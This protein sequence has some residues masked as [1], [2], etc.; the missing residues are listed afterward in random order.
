MKT[1]SIKNIVRKNNQRPNSKVLK[2]N[3]YPAIQY[4]TD[5]GHGGST[6][7][8][9]ENM[10]IFIVEGRFKFAFGKMDYTILES[11]MVFLKKDILIEHVVDTPSDFTN[12]SK[13]I[14]IQ[15]KQDLVKE[16]IKLARVSIKTQEES[17][18][19]IVDGID[20][21]LLN[22]IGSL[23]P[24]FAEPEKV[25]DHL[26]KIKL[27]ELLFNLAQVDSNILV[28]LMDLREH[29]QVDITSTVEENI[30]K[31]LSLHQLAVLS[32]RSLSSFRRDFMAIYN[33]PPSQWLRQKKLE[34]A[35][36]FLLNTTMTVTD[37]CY[38]LGFENLAHFSRLFKAHFGYSP[39]KSKLIALVA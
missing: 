7:F 15:L 1:V 6:I 13:Y 10:L 30:T 19:V 5:L 32:G 26:T 27:F 25:A 33:V 18:P 37:V 20:V 23:E 8:V 17:P 35:R 14:A 29:F 9:E 11:Q 4:C 38:T 16:F 22:F 24:Y 28:P 21:R 34:K 39:S 36:E 31:S 2:L 12:Q 3:G